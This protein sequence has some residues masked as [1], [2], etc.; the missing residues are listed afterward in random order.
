MTATKMNAS[1]LEAIGV[2]AGS[3]LQI[4]TSEEG[5]PIYKGIVKEMDRS[6]ILLQDDSAEIPDLIPFSIIVE[7]QV[8]TRSGNVGSVSN[9]VV[10]VRSEK[11]AFGTTSR[12][13]ILYDRKDIVMH[14]IG[15]IEMVNDV[16]NIMRNA[17]MSHGFTEIA[18]DL[19]IL[20]LPLNQELID[21]LFNSTLY[22]RNFIMNHIQKEIQ[23]AKTC[24]KDVNKIEFNEWMSEQ[25]KQ[26]NRKIGFC[27]IKDG[28]YTGGMCKDLDT[29]LQ[30]CRD[31]YAEDNSLGLSIGEF[32]SATTIW[33]TE[34][35][36]QE[37]GIIPA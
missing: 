26:G 21:N 30:R 22:F 7:I 24:I 15:D 19:A 6:G 18:N 5:K 35:I 25:L 8:V 9:Q 27:K 31:Y 16:Y 33:T 2:T 11:K 28:L 37:L 4:Q 1:E 32:H 14:K 10:E 34:D 29:A 3:Q 17:Y 12:P 36:L 13:A 20:E 23:T